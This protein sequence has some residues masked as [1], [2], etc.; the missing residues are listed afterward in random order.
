MTAIR[1]VS[2]RGGFSRRSNL[3]QVVY[4]GGSNIT[5]NDVTEDVKTI[6]RPRNR[7][8]KEKRLPVIATGSNRLFVFTGGQRA[9]DAVELPAM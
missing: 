4:L 7:L 6:S 3:G 8:A 5:R 2:L 9:D 1:A